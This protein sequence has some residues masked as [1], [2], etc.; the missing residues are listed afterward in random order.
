[1][2]QIG[3]RKRFK[4]FAKVGKNLSIPSVRHEMSDKGMWKFYLYP[5]KGINITSTK[6]F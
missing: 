2:L 1:M 4:F 6:N 3:V 5:S